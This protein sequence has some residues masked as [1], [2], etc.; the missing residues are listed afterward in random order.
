[1][2]IKENDERVVAVGASVPW[3]GGTRNHCYKGH[4]LE[5]IEVVYKIIHRRIQFKSIE[6]YNLN[7]SRITLRLYYTI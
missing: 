2:V 5:L 6:Q 3:W 4:Q 1:M 7:N